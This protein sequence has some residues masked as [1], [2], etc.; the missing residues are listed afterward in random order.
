MECKENVPFKGNI[1]F[2]S[3][4]AFSGYTLS[5]RDDVISLMYLLLYLVDSK[6]PWLDNDAPASNQFNDILNFKT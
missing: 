6:L 3:K 4:N 1:I 5:R 2:S